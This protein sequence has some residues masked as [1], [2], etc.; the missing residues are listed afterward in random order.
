MYCMISISEI[1]K[2]ATLSRIAL[3]ADEKKALQKD[4]DA[5]L[6]YVDQVKKV[7]A[8]V[9]TEKKA[10]ALRN[11]FRED[12]NPHESGIFTEELLSAAPKRE[13]QYIKVKKIL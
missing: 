13:G 4:M 6:D 1:E 2:L 8:T 3:S 7:S 10:G 9:G 11:V 12:A 5:I